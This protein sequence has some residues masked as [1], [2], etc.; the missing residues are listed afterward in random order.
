MFIKS[1]SQKV[2]LVT[3][4]RS[5]IIFYK[6][7]ACCHNLTSKM[8]IIYLQAGIDW[9]TGFVYGGNEWNCGTWMDKMGS[10]EKAGN[11]GKPA[12]PRQVHVV[13]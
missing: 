10:S 5:F 11:K 8:S 2:W 6:D 3:Q 9:Q 4:V 12:T 1:M 13:N 7:F